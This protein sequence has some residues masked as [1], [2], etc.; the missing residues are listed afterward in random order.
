MEN[1]KN[2]GNKIVCNRLGPR[3]SLHH[4]RMGPGPTQKTIG[5][6]A[7]LALPIPIRPAPT[8]LPITHHLPLT[9]S[10]YLPHSKP[11]PPLPPCLL[12]MLATMHRF[13]NASQPDL[14]AD[15]CLCL[16][17]KPPYYMGIGVIEPL[18]PPKNSEGCD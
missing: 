5:P 17:S 12:T 16:N 8:R 18:S 1:W 13:V 7:D 9:P 3:Y 15:C 14:G 10:S 11:L 6:L 4:P 2:M